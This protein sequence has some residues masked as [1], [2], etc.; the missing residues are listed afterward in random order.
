VNEPK[1]KERY[2]LLIE[3]QPGEVPAANRLRQLLKRLLRSL[4]MKCISIKPVS[5][6]QDVPR[7]EKTATVQR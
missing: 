2:A 3:V 6:G 5:A 7:E 4:G 1:A